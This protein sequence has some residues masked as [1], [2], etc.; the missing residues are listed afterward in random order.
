MLTFLSAALLGAG[1]LDAVLTADEAVAA[2]ARRETPVFECG[3][4]V[5]RSR[6]RRLTAQPL[7]QTS[8]AA[9][10]DRA[11]QLIAETGTEG[12]RPFVYLEQ[13]ELARLRG[14]DAG[15]EQA[16]R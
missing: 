1:D 7:S 10:L 2:S 15:A 16:E 11:L 3:A 4:L 6:V 12:W 13:A 8:G 9:D 14:D 5:T